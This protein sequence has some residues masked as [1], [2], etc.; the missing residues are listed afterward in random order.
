MSKDKKNTEFTVKR[1]VNVPLLKA[2]IGEPIYVKILTPIYQG[3]DMPAQPGK[4]K[5]DPA[6]LAKCVDLNTGELVEIIINA[7][8]QSIL[9]EEYPDNEYVGMFFQITK[10]AKATG[11]GYNPYVVNELEPVAVPDMGEV[12]V[13]DFSR[14]KDGSTVG[15]S[16]VD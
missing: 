15:D 4:K 1:R 5:M 16:V 8:L 2:V 12:K 9:V 7:V 14:V 11:K 10:F 6:R 13:P 3:K